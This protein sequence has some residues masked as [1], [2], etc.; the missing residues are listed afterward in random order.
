MHVGSPIFALPC[1]V[2]TSWLLDRQP[3]DNLALAD[4]AVFVLP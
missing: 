1:H 3:D 4:P 2:R